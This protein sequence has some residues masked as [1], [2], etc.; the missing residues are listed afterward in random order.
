[1]LSQRSVER[2]FVTVEG[3]R[4]HA[5][6]AGAGAPL[7][8][9]PGWPQSVYAFRHVIPKLAPHYRVIAIDPPGL[10][11]SDPLP[12]GADT[13]G[14]AAALHAAVA[15]LGHERVRFVG[16]D[17]GAWLGYSFSARFPDAVTGLVVVDGLVPGLGPQE[18]P[19]TPDRVRK[20]WHFFFNALPDLPEA[21]IAGREAL[22]LD[23]LFRSRSADPLSF[24]DADI[25]E[26]ARCYA[27][28]GRMK[29]GFAYYRAIF[30][31]A[32]QNRALAKSRLKMPVLAIGGG[33]W[34]GDAM[35]A[36]FATVA[37]DVRGAVIENCGH[38]VPEEA[39]QALADLILEFFASAG[40][41]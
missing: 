22:Y 25:A 2:R 15:A 3:V 28:A 13:D 14:V 36:M 32:A 30:T 38:Y 33:L 11:Y 37:D 16:H 8:L 4:I 31:S 39:P 21:L 27:R 26:Y 12:A 24:S 18:I 29:D 40:G 23:W 20:A 7:V 10:G 19:L 41:D 35:R 17:I 1:M 6:E 9:V 5:V 34:L